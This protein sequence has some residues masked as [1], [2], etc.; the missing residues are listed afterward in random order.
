MIRKNGGRE[1]APMRTGIRV[2]VAAVAASLA[3][4]GGGPVMARGAGCSV[5]LF[6]WRGGAVILSE[7]GR[8][9]RVRVQIADTP[10]RQ[11]VGLMCRNTLESDAGML[12]IFPAST[13]TSFWMKNT[14]IPLAIA[15][16]DANWHIV[17]IMEM[18][19]AP[20]P[21]SDDASAFPLYGP[22]QPFRYALEVNAGFFKAHGISEQGEV[23][24][25]QESQ[26]G[27]PQTPFII[28]LP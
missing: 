20:D 3:L 26:G 25:V 5:P 21:T 2:V 6:A 24:F 13:R 23:R 16:I 10:D 8:V 28:A 9:A 1:R 14:L 22:H 18:P 19:V 15:F 12:F 11:E 4:A 7:G 17:K 27:P